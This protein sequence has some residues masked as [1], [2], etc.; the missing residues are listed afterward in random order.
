MP[1]RPRI[2]LAGYYHIIS[3]RFKLDGYT[4]ADVARY[5]N[6]SKSLISKIIKSGDSTLGCNCVILM[7]D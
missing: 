1:T 4:Q 2:D 3:R 7:K 5:L 6:I